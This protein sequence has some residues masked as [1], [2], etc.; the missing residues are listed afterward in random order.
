MKS[1]FWN[2]AAVDGLLL[3]LVTILM[4]VVSSSFTLGKGLNT[5]LSIVKLIA[6]LGMLFYFMKDYG[7]D[8]TPYEYADAFKFGIATSFCSS[9]VG[10]AYYLIHVAYLFPDATTTLTNSFLESYAQL[11]ATSQASMDINALTSRLPLILAL[12][13]F[14]Y[15]NILG[16]IWSSLLAMAAKKT[17]ET[18][19]F[20]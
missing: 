7:K 19:P 4:V 15:F 1:N 17:V 13:Q 3:A 12:S 2:K 11:S 5:T 8:L 6:T 10:A 14:F 9:I 20:D 18:T 16:L